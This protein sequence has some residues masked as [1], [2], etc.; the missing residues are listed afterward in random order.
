[1]NNWIYE[2]YLIF[3]QPTISAVDSRIALNAS[4][5]FSFSINSLWHSSAFLAP[6][7]LLASGQGPISKPC[8]F[9]FRLMVD[10]I[11][12]A[13]SYCSWNASGLKSNIHIIT[14]YR[15]LSVSYSMD[16]IH[17]IM[18][19]YFHF[20][21]SMAI[22]RA[23]WLGNVIKDICQSLKIGL[24][25][26]LLPKLNILDKSL[27]VEWKDMFSGHYISPAW[28]LQTGTLYEKEQRYAFTL[29]Y[30]KTSH[31][32]DFLESWYQSGGAWECFV[33]KMYIFYNSGNN[34]Q[35]R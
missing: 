1:M 29:F 22:Y 5:D 33:N 31:T 20:F 11:I 17:Y 3:G 25:S 10:V 23:E 18:F 28:Q 35:H 9:F 27:P 4:L 8:D 30:K 19:P 26:L 24:F 21:F 32:S 6:P 14:H 13:V 7:I 12:I 2:K 15:G 34:T 16:W